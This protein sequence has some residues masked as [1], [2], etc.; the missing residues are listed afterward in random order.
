MTWRAESDVS[1]LITSMRQ[2]TRGSVTNKLVSDFFSP[3]ED[4]AEEDV[5]AISRLRDADGTEAPP[6]TT[7]HRRIQRRR[8]T[9]R[10]SRR[11][12][13]RTSGSTSPDNVFTAVHL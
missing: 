3:I 2:R 4:L 7:F 8:G 5:P 13:G 12:I 9:G 6:P 1:G 10:V 11:R